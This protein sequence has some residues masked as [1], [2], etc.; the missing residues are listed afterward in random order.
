MT[1]G[2]GGTDLCIVVLFGDNPAAAELET[3][4]G[5]ATRT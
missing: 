2:E 3:G 4:N 1:R 5:F